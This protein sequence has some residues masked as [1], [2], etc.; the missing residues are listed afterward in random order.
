MAVVGLV[1]GAVSAS[2]GAEGAKAATPG[3]AAFEALKGLE[4]IWVGEGGDGEQKFPGRVEYRNA[5][6][7]T[8]VMETLFPGDP[9]EMISMYHLDGGELVMTHYC[10]MGNQ[11]RM[12]LDTAH[13]TPQHLV[14]EFAG[15]TNFDP[16]RDGHIHSGEIRISPE[17]SYQASWAY[18]DKG[19]LAGTK[20][21]KLG[22]R[23]D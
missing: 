1:L 8:V 13:S 18:W 11:P 14:F 3:A 9:H 19:K 15:G 4:G 16:K 6:G 17:G 21:F 20:Q 5:S 22:R 7:G 12:K 2:F 23:S 10:A